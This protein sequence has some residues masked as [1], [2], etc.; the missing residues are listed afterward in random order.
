MC[1]QLS[2][3]LS[4]SLVTQHLLIL[5]LIKQLL[6]YAKLQ[7]TRQAGDESAII[8][9]DAAI[10]SDTIGSTAFVS[11]VATNAP[12]KWIVPDGGGG[13]GG[14]AVCQTFLSHV[15]LLHDLY[16]EDCGVTC[17]VEDL[18]TI[19]PSRV[20]CVSIFSILVWVCVLTIAFGACVCVCVQRTRVVREFFA[21]S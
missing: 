7:F 20:G 16:M 15:D 5:N 17:T 9:G 8:S 2:S 3:W 4:A 18:G 1:H 10:T 6:F 12:D 13:E 11:S 14:V 19:I 21:T